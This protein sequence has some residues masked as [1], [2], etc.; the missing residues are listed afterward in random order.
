MKNLIVLVSTLALAAACSKS[1]TEDKAAP[2]TKA[3]EPAK[4][5]E[6]A[7]TAEP[8]KVDPAAAPTATGH[9]DCCCLG[10]KTG[11]FI[12]Y[13][14]DVCAKAGGTCDTTNSEECKKLKAA[15]EAAAA[16]MDD[17][18]AEERLKADEQC[19][20]GNRKD[21]DGDGAM[22]GEDKDDTNPKV[23]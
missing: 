8:A 12:A 23:R 22:A 17:H 14:G 4:V 19:S 21:C 2:A 1:K 5:A 18:V 10:A 7:K 15:D 11:S 20:S 13:D 16:A 3:T 6:P 9:T